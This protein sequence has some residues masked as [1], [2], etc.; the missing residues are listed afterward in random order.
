[1]KKQLLPADRQRI[2]AIWINRILIVIVV[3]LGFL[4]GYFHAKMSTLEKKLIEQSV[5]VE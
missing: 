4:A 5:M 1:M 3:C 2:S